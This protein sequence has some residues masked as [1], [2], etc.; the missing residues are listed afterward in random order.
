MSTLSEKE[1]TVV[2]TFAAEAA[3]PTTV[4]GKEELQYLLYCRQLIEKFAETYPCDC[5]CERNKPLLSRPIDYHLAAL[6][7]VSTYKNET[8]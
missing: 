5:G 3:S 7:A 6:D 2:R 8:N 1:D 4:I